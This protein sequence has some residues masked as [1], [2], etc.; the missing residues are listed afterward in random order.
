MRLEDNLYSI[1]LIFNFEDESDSKLDLV[2]TLG[3]QKK[4]RT[5][6]TYFLSK[7]IGKNKKKI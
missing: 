1:T 5:V 2:S 7:V 3:G 4:K 6:P